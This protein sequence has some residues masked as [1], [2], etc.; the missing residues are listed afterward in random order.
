MPKIELNHKTTKG[1]IVLDQIRTIDR[2]R[3]IKKV[4]ELSEK[5][6]SKTKLEK[7]IVRVILRAVNGNGKRDIEKSI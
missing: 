2:T 7:R 4:G 5:E 3:I 1:F 6:I